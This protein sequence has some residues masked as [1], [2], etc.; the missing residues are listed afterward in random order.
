MLSAWHDPAAR[1]LNVDLVAVL[2]RAVTAVVDVRRRH[3]G[4][5]M[6]CRA[7]SD[8]ATCGHLLACC[9]IRFAGCPS[10]CLRSPLLGT[11]WSDAPWDARTYALSPVAKLLVLPLLFYHFERSPRGM[12]VFVAFLVSCTLLMVMSWLVLFVSRPRRS[13]RRRQSRR[14]GQEL[15]DQSQEFALCAVALAYPV[16]T[17][18]AGQKIW[19]ALLLVAIA[20]RFVVNMMFV[21][22]VAH[23]A[24]HDA[25]HARGVRAAAPEMANQRR[26]SS[27]RRS[28]WR[29]WRG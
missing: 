18:L 12:W 27:W 26:P 8:A 25:D 23:G 24:G 2:H 5:D 29:G 1:I 16:I 22:R 14:S 3:L 9:G 10:R 4:S 11:L 19:P 21:S 28:S 15:I 7:D 13:S 6:A 17:L 20:L